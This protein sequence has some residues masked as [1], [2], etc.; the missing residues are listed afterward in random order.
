MGLSEWMYGLL[1]DQGELGVIVFVFLIFFID[2]LIFPTLPEV[3]FILGYMYK[4]N[5]LVFGA[6]LLVTASIGE[7]AGIFLLYLIVK[8]IRLPEKIK[9][10]AD[11]YIDFL[12]VSDEKVFL[13]NRFAPMIPFAG[14]FISLV[15][16]WSLKKCMFYI[17]IGCYI[18][19]GIILMF[20]D[21]FFTFF[22]SGT[23]ETFTIIM[24]LTVIAISFVLSFRKK[25]REGL[26]S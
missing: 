3:F 10:V 14:A 9:R 7:I 18:K 5:N 26:S 16:R 25:K 23:A 8:K 12:M 15:G 20:S 1:G 6:E 4:P 24:V 11:K 21:F 17:I 2:A 22:D 19:Y 13:V